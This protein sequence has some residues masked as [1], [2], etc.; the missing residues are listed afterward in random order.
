MTPKLSAL[1]L[2]LEIFDYE[3][4]DQYR[5]SSYNRAVI[6]DA[7][8]IPLIYYGEKIGYRY[9][10]VSIC[11]Y[12]LFCAYENKLN[13]FLN[14]VNWLLK[15]SI[16]IDEAIVWYIDF[17]PDMNK[18]GY[19]WMSGLAQAMAIFVFLRAYE[20]LNDPKYLDY[21]E[22]AFNGFLLPIS[23]GGPLYIDSRGQLWIEE[24]PVL[25]PPNHVLNGFI[26]AV[27]SIFEL[28]LYTGKPKYYKFF[29]VFSSTIKSNIRLYDLIVWSRYN[30]YFKRV[31]TE[32]YAHLNAILLLLL[33]YLL[34][35]EYLKR[36]AKRWYYF[37]HVMRRI[38]GKII[39]I[40]TRSRM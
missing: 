20:I 17:R 9:N 31:A 13:C 39:D 25:W 29:K 40:Y 1:R 21:A 27:L 22:K 23:L 18:D 16:K 12:G 11:L 6:Y 4:V 34:D 3:N 32:K 38:I 19:K 28:Y 10:P 15:N 26:F 2:L 36:V 8:G 5:N 35:D 37:F 24:D 33:A 7:S 14:V 30:A